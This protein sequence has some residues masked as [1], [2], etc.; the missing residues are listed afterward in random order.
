MR[1]KPEQEFQQRIIELARIAGFEHIY[2]TFD[3]RHSPAGFPD[4]ILLKGGRQIV[5]EVKG[6]YKGQPT[7]EQYFWLVEFSK[8]TK[9]TY[10]WRPEDWEEIKKVLG[11]SEWQQ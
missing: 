1:N 5:A 2:H 11:V 6:D 4:L 9:D 7:P 10:F 8:V 3:S